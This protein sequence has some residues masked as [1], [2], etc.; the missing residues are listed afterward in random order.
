MVK[1]NVNQNEPKEFDLGERKV[2]RMNFSDVVTLPKTFTKNCLG[3]NKMV[4]MTMN[5]DGSLTLRSV[6]EEHERR[7]CSNE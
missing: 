6:D 3:E 2:S 7:I 4:K 5:A 1:Q